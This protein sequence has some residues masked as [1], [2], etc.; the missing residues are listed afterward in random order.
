MQQR[1][2]AP[3]S[4]L[5]CSLSLLLGASHKLPG[6]FCASTANIAKQAQTRIP[7][8]AYFPLAPESPLLSH[9]QMR[10]SSRLGL[11]LLLSLF[12]V[13]F[14]RTAWVSDDAFISFRVIDN[15]LNGHGLVWNVNE[16]VQAF[17]HPLWLFLLS[18]GVYFT[19][20]PY[21][22]SLLLS[23]LCSLGALWFSWRALSASVPPLALVCGLG[24]LFLSRAWVDYSSSGLE[25]PLQH[26]LLVLFWMVGGTSGSNRPLFH[27]AG[28][29]VF[30]TSLLFLTRPDAIVLVL[31]LLLS[32]LWQWSK[33]AHSLRHL[34]QAI[35]LGSLP[36]LLWEAF[37]LIYY[38]SLL[39]NTA[40][41][42]T[43]ILYPRL[44]LL[45]NGWNYLS[46]TFFQDPASFSLLVAAGLVTLFSP[47]KDLRPAGL[48][49]FLHV[50]YLFY[51]GGDFMGGRFLSSS[52]L[53]A[54]LL[55]LC[56]L[57]RLTQRPVLPLSFL[58]LS[59]VQASTST[60]FA[61]SSY[62]PPL[63]A[64]TGVADER[65][66]YGYELGLRNV[67]EWGTW[68]AHPWYQEG[69]RL[70]KEPG[71]YLRATVGMT[72]FAAGP[73]L[74]LIDPYALGNPFLARLP[75][76]EHSR[77]GH[78][79]RALPEGYLLSE[80]SGQNQLRDPVLSQ[81]YEDVQRLSRG[82]LFSLP[83]FQSIGRLLFWDARRAV[84]SFQRN[85]VQ[86]LGSETNI[87]SCFGSSTGGEASLRVTLTPDSQV[88]ILPREGVSLEKDPDGR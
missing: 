22:T 87:F 17:T 29:L 32:R 12:S 2:G 18:T 10:G 45:Q 23:F 84:H 25:N 82:P 53:W 85:Q 49:L 3:K 38:G 16:R 44:E 35:L 88:L 73:Q 79:E 11:L 78:Y 75:A 42:K 76:R 34:A 27:K 86:L 4:S 26:L 68:Q 13:T 50:L 56:G 30:L 83:R 54:V 47:H 41:A 46:W 69:L 6:E 52:V 33:G 61:T 51:V 71:T 19:Q 5:A 72:G 36:V 9:S 62:K 31:P 67:L 7:P 1:P 63:L 65:S 55:L 64:W 37:S 59:H 14:Y 74:H 28:I 20:D 39:P 24:L 48:G 77:I 70:Q 21:W 15:F 80:L 40:L 58:L 66:F 81:L 43:Q 8:I 60:L 57:P